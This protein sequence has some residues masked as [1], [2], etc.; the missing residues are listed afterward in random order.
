[1]SHAP[2][3][4]AA[5][6]P[7]AML[8]VAA[9]RGNRFG[10]S[11]PK[12]Y[13][14][15]AGQPLLFRTLEA[16]HRHPLVSTIQVVIARDDEHYHQ[17]IT[18]LLHLLPKVRPPVFGGAERQ[19]SVQKGLDALEL[20][21]D[22]WVGIHDAARPLLSLSLLDRLLAARD[23]VQ[24]LI[25]ALAAQDTIKQSDGS[26]FIQ[27]TIPR[28]TIWLAQTPQLFHLGLI[29]QAH[30]TYDR[31]LPA[32]DD[33]A[34]VEKLGFPVLLVEGESQNIKITRR[35]D[36]ALAEWYLANPQS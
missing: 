35:Q 21:Q 25:P 32:T 7:C 16:L 30:E 13:H 19:D 15:L 17:V 2:H 33:A 8:V 9:G 22:H 34:M 14:P 5:S 3:T 29:R 4:S 1:M 10:D 12:Q 26:H 36:L 24:A 31:N 28:Q 6:S 23:G 20:P 11:L 27:Q 18:P